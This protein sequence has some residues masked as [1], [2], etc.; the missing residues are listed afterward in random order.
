MSDYTI[1]YEDG[2]G[3]RATY[4]VT[5]PSNLTET[6]ARLSAIEKFHKE[7]D[8]FTDAEEGGEHNFEVIDCYLTSSAISH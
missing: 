8:K 7:T 1:V 5:V 3:I 6:A 4:R 2:H